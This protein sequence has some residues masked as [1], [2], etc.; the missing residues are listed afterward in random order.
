MIG[1][2]YADI[3]VVDGPLVLTPLGRDLMAGDHR[4]AGRVANRTCTASRSWA[5]L[6]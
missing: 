2:M 1:V 6:R 3:T 4:H 5:A